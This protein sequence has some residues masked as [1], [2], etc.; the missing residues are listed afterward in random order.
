MNQRAKIILFLILFFAPVL[1]NAEVSINEIMYDAPGTDSGHEWIEVYNSGGSSVNLSGWKF[2]EEGSNHGLSEYQGGMTISSNGYAVIVSDPAKFLEDYPGH[3]GIIIDSSWS[4]F[5]NAGE[6]LA[7]KDNNNSLIFEVTYVGGGQASGDGNSL[8]YVNGSWLAA[9]PTPGATNSDE[10]IDPNNQN[11]G[12]ENNT[13]NTSTTSTS[14]E[15]EVLTKV[16]DGTIVKV[17]VDSNAIVGVPFKFK[18][19]AYDEFGRE[20]NVGVFEWNFGDG[21]TTYEK[22]VLEFF[23]TYKKVGKYVAFLDYF[24]RSRNIEPD[25]TLKIIVNVIEPGIKIESIDSSGNIEIKNEGGTER[26]I[27][28]WVLVFNNQNFTFPK[29]SL[30]LAKSSMFINSLAHNFFGLTTSSRLNLYLPT[31][32]FYASFPETINPKSISSSSSSSAKKVV[33]STVVEKSEEVSN[34]YPESQSASVFLTSDKMKDGGLNPKIFIGA[35][36]LFCLIILFAFYRFNKNKPK[37]EDEADEYKIL[38]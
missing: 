27:S 38:S 20:L 11:T 15:K 9:I 28:G 16:Y 5:N 32:E 22:D 30:L 29:H 31:N 18:V 7:L 1:A 3:S 2:Y 23:H 17:Q 25:A 13:E 34:I 36:V 4:S 10:V 24:E 6:S 12:G 37:D 33:K 14:N 35:F 8:Q 19:S 21:M 26:D